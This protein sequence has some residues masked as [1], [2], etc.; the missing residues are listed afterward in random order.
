M[1]KKTKDFMVNGILE[2]DDS[3]M[4]YFGLFKFPQSDTLK[5]SPSS[6]FAKFLKR[7]RIQFF[8]SGVISI[9]FLQITQKAS[10]KEESSSY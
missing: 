8:D 5:L 4:K 9:I 10:M 1:K 3:Q 7:R 6:I 2:E